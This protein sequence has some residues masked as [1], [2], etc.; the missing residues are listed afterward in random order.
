MILQTLKLLIF[1]YSAN[2]NNKEKYWYISNFKPFKNYSEYDNYD[3]NSAKDNS[4][5][6]NFFM[7][8]NIDV[9]RHTIY[10]SP[11]EIVVIVFSSLFIIIPGSA[12]SIS[13][14]K[15]KNKKK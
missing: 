10:F 9:K 1:I 13:F 8:S 12:L 11:G 14:F 4:M 7:N 3:E 6:D 15:R 2:Y 5:S